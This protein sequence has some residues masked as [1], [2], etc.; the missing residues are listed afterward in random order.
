MYDYNRLSLSQPSW[1]FHTL[2]IGSPQSKSLR[3]YAGQVD[4]AD[5]SRFSIRYTLDGKDG[6]ILGR[7]SDRGDI[8][9]FEFPAIAEMR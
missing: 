4:A 1:F 7:L 3:F 9:R 5:G 2:P 6:T 8:V